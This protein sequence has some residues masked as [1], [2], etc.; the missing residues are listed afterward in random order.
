MDRGIPIYCKNLRRALE[1][2]GHHVVELCCPAWA[3]GLPK[4]VQNVL[5]ML[6]EQFLMPVL[7][8]FY[9]R[10][11]YPYNTASVL[12][13]LHTGALLVVHDF[14]PNRK[15]DKGLVARYVRMTQW[16]HAALGR[17]VACVS[18][19]TYRVA[20]K[21]NAFAKSRKLVLPNGFWTF[22]A[23][24]NGLSFPQGEQILLCTGVGKNK[25]L[26][27]ALD[28]YASILSE[29]RIPLAL[30]G[31]AGDTGIMQ[32]WLAEHPEINPTLIRVLPRLTDREVV[33]VYMRSRWVWVH[34]R[35]EGYGR[36]IAEA[37]CCAK[38]TIATNIP[39]F[40]DQKDQ[41]VQLYGD[42]Q[43]FERAVAALEG[44]DRS[45]LRPQEPTEDKLLVKNIR[46]WLRTSS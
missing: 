9:S 30:L 46:L 11:V 37:K 26:K 2:E 7:S 27:G 24:I 32:G 17:D 44:I 45:A 14:I 15:S 28:L 38:Y 20:Q 21:V 10:S 25:D 36:S 35:S 18:Y 43:S 41:T 12:G 34:S 13:S 8:I 4:S 3:H 31:L 39:P 5:F 16:V 6:C 1:I 40:R 29:R 33:E 19:A 22:R 23:A 42:R